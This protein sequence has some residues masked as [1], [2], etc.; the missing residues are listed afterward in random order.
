MKVDHRRRNVDMTE[1]FLHG[2]DVVAGFKQVGG[3]TAAAYAWML[4]SL[5]CPAKPGSVVELCRSG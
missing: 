5:A 4:V 2:A 3:K 1:Q